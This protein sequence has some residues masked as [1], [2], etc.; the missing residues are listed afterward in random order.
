MNYF[1][2]G[3]SLITHLESLNL[4]KKIAFVQSLNDV[5][6]NKQITPAAYVVY[7]GDTVADTVGRGEKTKITQRYS[8]VIAVANAQSQIDVVAMIE[9]AGELIP[10]ALKA[11]NGW[12]AT[13]FH[14]PFKRVSGDMAGFSNSFSYYP[15][16]FETTFTI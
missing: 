11:L 12:Q 6:E 5:G 13:E 14:S 1:A 7:R 15:F 10:T 9:D 3:L 4:F 2:V 16:T 8:V